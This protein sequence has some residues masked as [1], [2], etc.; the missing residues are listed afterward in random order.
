MFDYNETLFGRSNANQR[1]G[2]TNITY[3]VLVAKP[4]AGPMADGRPNICL[5]MF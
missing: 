2:R 4:S 5:Q 1:N 3:D